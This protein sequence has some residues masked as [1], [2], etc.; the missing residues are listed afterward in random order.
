MNNK[1][2]ELDI[3]FIHVPKFHDRFPP[4][5]ESSFINVIPSGVQGM[6]DFLDKKG[7][8]SRILHLGID[9]IKTGAF[10]PTG[11]LKKH[12]VK[13]VGISLHWHHQ[14]Y[15][16]IETARKIKESFPHIPIILGGLTASYFARE[17]LED[18]SFI[19]FVITGDGEVP[20]W[21]LLN[22]IKKNGPEP[23]PDDLRNLPNLYYRDGDEVKI[24]RALYR[25]SQDILD[26]LEHFRPDLMEDWE[27][28]RL[29]M[30]IPAIWLQGRSPEYHRDNLHRLTNVYFPMTGKGCPFQC[31]WCGKE[32]R[33]KFIFRNPRK[34]AES[35]QKAYNGGVESVYFTF[36]PCRESGE[37]YRELFRIMREMKLDLFGYF[38]CWGLPSHG[39][40]TDFKWTFPDRVM[41]LSPETGSEELRKQNKGIYYSNRELEETLDL[42]KSLEIETDLFF[43][44][45]I[46]GENEEKFQETAGYIRRC[47][48][49]YANIQEACLFCIELEPGS[50]WFENPEKYGIITGR[51]SFRDYYHAHG[52]GNRGSFEAAGYYI[53]DYFREG[54]KS[55]EAFE[56]SINQLR[57][58]TVSMPDT[59]LKKDPGEREWG[60]KQE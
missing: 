5:G 26:S 54:C 36:D 12:P 57:N 28:Y 39:L 46:P 41:A 19:D 27:F 9:W 56:D 22:L 24:S 8:S 21:E 45:G 30:G 13:A 7:I 51:K 53:P 49:K 25:L 34:V 55:I 23:S 29:E 52:P 18:Y 50:P 1:S 20:L 38:E 14:S 16:V 15:D 58:S 40:L 44:M 43:A 33:G 32:R 4:F 10:D 59:F 11:Y 42:L 31:S 60:G 47:R 2:R 3:L 17:I 48:E 37:Y 6:A 35:I